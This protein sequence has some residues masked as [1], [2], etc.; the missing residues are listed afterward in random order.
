MKLVFA[1]GGS[2]VVPENIDYT[3]IRRFADFATR[4]SKKHQIVI[5]VGGGRTARRAISKAKEDG[6]NQV[7]CDY[8]GI[9]A[10]RENAKMLIDALDGNANS[11]VPQ[12]FI[13]AKREFEDGKIVVMGGTEPG[14]STDAVAII[15]GEYIDANIIFKITDVDGI[16]DKDPQKFDDAKR[17]EFLSLDKLQEMVLGLSQEAGKYE[18]VDMVGVK[19]L[20]RS[21]IKCIALSGHDFDNIDKAI[22]GK[23]FTGTVIQ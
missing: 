8:A 1:L 23:K 19:I 22:E 2:V 17:Y 7:E 5:V 16:Y 13:S 11:D 21:G 18:L 14:H 9:D 3:Y 4:L 15:I 20:Q 6:A 10:S 12:D